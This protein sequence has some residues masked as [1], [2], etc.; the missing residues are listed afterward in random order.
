MDAACPILG[1]E[2]PDDIA[3][4][5]LAGLS[6][7]SSAAAGSV[8]VLGMT[9]IDVFGASWL[10]E[11]QP[12]LGFSWSTVGGQSSR[13]RLFL[14]R[15]VKPLHTKVSPSVVSLPA[16]GA[17]AAG[18]S[19]A[20]LSAAG[21]GPAGSSATGLSA[22]D[23][24]GESRTTAAQCSAGA[25]GSLTTGLS[26][27]GAGA[28]GLSATCLSAADSASESGTTAAQCPAGAAGTPATGLCAADSAGA[29]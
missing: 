19:V 25:T 16:V 9:V 1:R 27:A 18:S 14:Q 24:V 17:G 5:S 26:A 15:T 10:V 8:S 20:G 7:M 4:V 29:S 23:Y 2:P 13:S 12:R 11:V 22:A 21:A 6:T 3:E 28:A